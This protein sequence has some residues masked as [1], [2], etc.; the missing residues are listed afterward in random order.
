MYVCMY[1]CICMYLYVYVCI[2]MYMYV[3]VCICMY[4]YVYVCICMYMY[5]YVCMYACMYVCMYA[6]MYVM[7]VCMYLIYFAKTH[8]THK[9]THI[10]TYIHIY[11]YTP[12]CTKIDSEPCWLRALAASGNTDW[13]SRWSSWRDCRRF[14]GRRFLAKT[15]LFFLLNR[16]Q[17]IKQ[18]RVADSLLICF[19]VPECPIDVDPMS[20]LCGVLLFLVKRLWYSHC[21]AVV[22]RET[23]IHACM[24]TYIHS[25][26]HAFMHAY[27]HTHITHTHTYTHI[28]I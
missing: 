10:H 5:V 27:I 23:Y 11:L 21:I 15:L 17:M 28:Y 16:Q 9:H 8:H 24:H 26:I 12:G 7:Y 20:H 2:C 14:L 25:S 6:C 3:Y 4:M 13:R 19:A 22:L 1:I 18:R